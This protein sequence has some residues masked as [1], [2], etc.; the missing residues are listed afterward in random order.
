MREFKQERNLVCFKFGREAHTP[1]EHPER[2][3]KL[4]AR[5]EHVADRIQRVAN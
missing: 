3:L 4:V 5:R 1:F 2:V